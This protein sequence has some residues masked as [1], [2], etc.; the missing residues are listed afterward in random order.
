MVPALSF[1]ALEIH[2]HLREVDMQFPL[3]LNDLISLDGKQ[4]R[5]VRERFAAI[6][7]TDKAYSHTVRKPQND[8]VMPECWSRKDGTMTNRGEMNTTFLF[9]DY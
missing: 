3:E 7:D 4:E 5:V 2:I 8:R 6:P 1:C 9:G